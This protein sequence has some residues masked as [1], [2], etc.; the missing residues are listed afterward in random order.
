MSSSW[1]LIDFHAQHGV[2][3]LCIVCFTSSPIMATPNYFTCTLGEAASLRLT[4]ADFKN[5][6]TFVDSL[7]QSNPTSPAVGFAI[8][9]AKDRDEAW[10]TVIY[11]FSDV[12]TG[13]KSTA[14]YFKQHYAQKLDKSKTVAL[15]CPS[16]PQI[17]LYMAGLDATWPSSAPDSA[18]MSTCCHS[19]LVQKLQRDFAIP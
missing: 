16:T 2:D 10:G 5:I 14:A 13:S 19:T 4:N 15:I 12:S 6:T 8:P 1:V 18:T 9:N 7:A 11:S 3:F 17:S